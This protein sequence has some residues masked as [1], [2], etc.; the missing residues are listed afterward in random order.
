MTTTA[1]NLTTLE[2]ARDL[3]RGQADAVDHL[4]EVMRTHDEFPARAAY[5]TA[6]RAG[7]A[8]P[9]ARDLVARAASKQF[10]AR[11]RLNDAI[12]A[13]REATNAV[14]RLIDAAQDGQR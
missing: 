2:S 7:I 13:L 5:I 8:D 6:R 10:H 1:A 11:H 14:N 3:L 9:A 12:H 4:V